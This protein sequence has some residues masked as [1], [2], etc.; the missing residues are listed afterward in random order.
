[1]RMA[2]VAISPPVL[3]LASGS[4][5]RAT[6]LAAAGIA[7]DVAPANIDERG[8]EA[9]LAGASPAQT[10]LALAESKARAVS[11]ERPGRLVLGGD[12]LV[13]CAGRRFDKPA[14]QEDAAAH[15]RY[16]SGRVME[17]T[18][19]AALARDGVTV[20]RHAEAALLHVRVLSEAFIA[21]YLAA[22][23]PA[24][25]GCVGVFRMEGMGV[26]LFERVE[27]DHFTILGMPLLAVLAGL[28]AQGALE[29]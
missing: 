13:I 11:R 7:C 17:L 10:A 8:L 26:Q 22:E 23:W 19:A 6:M 3:I 15:L 24:V 12:S 28:R 25:G 9:S 16:F 5:S 14:S 20:W 4:A 2:H 18:S 29:E 1:M 27:G 21:Q